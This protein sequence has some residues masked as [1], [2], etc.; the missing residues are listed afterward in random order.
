MKTK[1]INEPANV[2]PELLEGYVLCYPD[3]V[4]L[5]GENIIVRANPKDEGKVAIV[6]LGGSGHEPALSGFVGEGMLDCS[7]VGDVFAAPGAQRLF[8]ALQ[9]MKREAGILLVV[10]NHS[11]DVMSANMACQLAERAGI[12]VRQLVTHDDISAGIGAPAD[13]RRGLAGCIP[14]YKVIG[15][16]AEEG[17]SLDELIEIGERFNKRIATLAVATGKCT[18]PQNNALISDLP[19]GIM[20]IGMGQHGEGGG[21]QKPLVSADDTAVEMVDLLCR[22]LQ[23]KSEDKMLLI[24]N[25][26][27]ATTQMEHNII[28]RKAYKELQA[29]G[30][31]V[32]ASRIQEILT[33]Q[34][35][36]GFQMIMAILDDDHIDYLNNKKADAPYWTTIGK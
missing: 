22:Q 27:G 6:T 18:H 1:F 21:G 14:L 17:K 20:E 25:G 15:A 23:P 11:G 5:G 9:L 32:V 12:R 4:K 30:M 29:R 34:E 8:Q 10:L 13:D 16:A 7:V 3:K 33:V 2:T 35:Q 26:T 31:K 28:F 36:A 24:I 19:P